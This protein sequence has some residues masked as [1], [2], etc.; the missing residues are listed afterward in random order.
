M[1]IFNHILH[2]FMVTGAVFYAVPLKYWTYLME[3]I[4]PFRLIFNITNF[5]FIGADERFMYTV[6]IGS[7]NK[8]AIFSN[9]A[10]EYIFIS[11]LM[12]TLAPLIDNA[13]APINLSKKT[14]LFKVI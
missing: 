5:V 4:L 11:F 10:V 12:G 13:L 8:L 14:P 2:V 1:G 3:K 9:P 7:P 6:T